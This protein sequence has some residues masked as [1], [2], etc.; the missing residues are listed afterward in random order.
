MSNDTLRFCKNCGKDITGTDARRKF[1]SDRCK[2]AWRVSQLDVHIST[3]KGCGA[4]IKY[5]LLAGKPSRLYCSTAC[6]LK[7]S[8]PTKILTCVDCGKQFE[9][10]GRTVKLRCSECWNKNRSKNAMARRA[11]HDPTVQVGVGSGGHQ[12]E[13][14]T[15]SDEV[16][17]AINQRRREFYAAHREEMRAIANARYRAKKLTGNDECVLCGYRQHQEALIVHHKNMSR[18]DN[19]DDNLAILC[20]NCHVWLHKLIRRRQKTESI[21]AT[22][23]FNEELKK[24]EVKERNKA[25]T[26]DRAIRTEGLKEFK[27]G[28]TH[29]S[30]SRSDMN[31]HEAAPLVE[32]LSFDF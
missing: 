18:V 1:C 9:F 17:A 29:S 25:G 16:R 6:Q 11:L 3:C 7:H 12:N 31:C 20:S 14:T 26:P 5:K 24:A 27:S 23:I 13:E 32:D 19:T 2:E 15:I 22:D 10:H 28:A 4:P 8:V 21:T 30:T